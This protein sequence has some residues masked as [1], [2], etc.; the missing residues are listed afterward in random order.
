[1]FHT[2]TLK[3]LFPS[4]GKAEGLFVPLSKF[5]DHCGLNSIRK[6]C[7]LQMGSSHNAQKLKSDLARQ[8]AAGGAFVLL[9]RAVFLPFHNF[10]EKSS[11]IQQ[12]QQ[13][14]A[15]FLVHSFLMNIFLNMHLDIDFR[16]RIHS[17]FNFLLNA[18]CC[19]PKCIEFNI[20]TVKGSEGNLVLDV[21]SCMHFYALY[22]NNF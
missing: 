12:Q 22:P 6:S 1:M 2:I 4:R 21:F 10:Q 5:Q 9:V 19:F 14:V 16:D 20:H 17:V 8:K 13:K 7:L 15:S 11:V 18:L 3:C